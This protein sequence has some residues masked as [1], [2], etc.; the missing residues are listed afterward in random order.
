MQ[1][2]S[3]VAIFF[4]IWWLTFFI[5]L[6]FG[7]RRLQGDAERIKGSDAGAPARTLLW[8]KALITT[9]LAAAFFAAVY[10]VIVDSGLTLA[11]VPLPMPPV[12]RDD[13]AW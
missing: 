2:G 10:W 11:D 5:V 9:V 13:P 6:P 4:I 3:A 1:I 7:G 8:R 12:G